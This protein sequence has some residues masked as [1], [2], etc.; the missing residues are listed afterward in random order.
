MIKGILTIFS[1]YV[2]PFEK[3]ADKFFKSVKSGS[4]RGKTHKRLEVLMQE[5]L[6]IL[7]LW[8]EK[9]YKNYVYLKKGVRRQMYTDVEILK[10]D[11]LK[12][13]AGFKP[14][15]TTIQGKFKNLGVSFPTN[16]V[17]K[18]T[19]LAAIMSYLRPGGRYTYEE[20]ANFGKLLKN[21]LE[22]K[23]IGDCNQIVTLYSFLYSLKY[24]IRDLNIKLVPGHVCLHFRGIDIEATNGS[25]KKYT[26]HDGVLAITELLTTNLLDVVDADAR[27]KQ[28]EPRVMLKRAQLAHLISSKRD[29]VE[30]NL[31]IAYRNLGIRLMN[32][33]EFNSALFYV[34]KT[35]DPKLL[36]TIYH[37]GAIHYLKRK[38]FKRAKYFAKRSGKDNLMQACYMGEYRELSKK[39]RGI[40]SL[41]KA[42]AQK[43][44]YRK[45][46]DLARKGGDAK[47]EASVQKILGQL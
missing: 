37:N 33:K 20:S 31:Q 43:S 16:D 12:Y 6:V 4:S 35:R 15:V 42:R 36:A 5:N 26:K 11:F 1:R 9:K 28:I 29:L 44:T 25:F 19:F 14:N 7:N 13:A 17:D 34:E 3:K 22:Q 10:E 23:L 8:M 39:V 38:N 24:P 40:K 21:P 27:T 45:M 47:A 46:L 2:H 18:V 32:E 30:R 41:D